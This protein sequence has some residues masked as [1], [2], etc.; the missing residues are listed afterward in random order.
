MTAGV[1][2]MASDRPAR[3]ALVGPPNSGKTTLFNTLTGGRQKTANYPGV[4]VERKSGLLPLLSSFACAIPG[5]MATRT[6]S[7]PLDRLVTILIAPLMTCS[8]RLPVYVLL[9][10]AFVPNTVVWGGIGLQGLVMF[11][12]YATGIVGALG[13]AGVLRLT[14]RAVVGNH[15]LMELPSYK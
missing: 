4:T 2:T 8:A 3:I 12:L 6:I 13:V 5:I 10:A 7:H 9:I 11:G 15:L 14:L 1:L